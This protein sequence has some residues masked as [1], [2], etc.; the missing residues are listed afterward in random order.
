M[1]R[2][3]SALLNV[4]SADSGSGIYGAA[5]KVTYEVNDQP[6]EGGREDHNLIHLLPPRYLFPLGNGGDDEER[7]ENAYLVI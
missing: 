6:K 5:T 3:S 7:N 4:R 1:R 2:G